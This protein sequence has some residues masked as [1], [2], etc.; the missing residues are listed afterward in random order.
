MRDLTETLPRHVLVVDDSRAQRHVL[1]MHLSRWG[2]LVTEAA[3]GAEALALA[4]ARP[5]DLV[6]SDWMMPGLTGPELCRAFRALPRDGYGYFILLTSKSGQEAIATG[7]D[8]G[9]DDFLTKPV[10]ALELRARLR[11]GDRILGMQAELLAKNH[12]LRR[13]HDA[14][15]A[16]LAQARRLQQSLIRDRHRDYAAGAVSLMM[17]PSGHVGGDLVGRPGDHRA[18]GG[19]LPRDGVKADGPAQFGAA[20]VRL[21]QF[22]Q[23]RF[24]PSPPAETEIEQR[25]VLVE[26][27]AVDHAFLSLQLP[28]PAVPPPC[29]RPGRESS[30]QVQCGPCP[31]GN[32]ARACKGRS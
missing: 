30:R 23:Q 28:V 29:R 16:D 25:A 10:S 32:I 20:G 31:P 7:L 26:N 17:R 11:A 4:E 14:M 13:A 8:G 1:A 27:D 5:F 9:A 22:L 6:I 15:E 19:E 12:A 18:V 2:Y 21:G 3:T 24:R